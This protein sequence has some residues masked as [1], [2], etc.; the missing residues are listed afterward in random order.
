MYLKIVWQEKNEYLG[1]CKPPP[2]PPPPRG[3]TGEEGDLATA[4]IP[5]NQSGFVTPT[6]TSK[7]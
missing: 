7:I 1:G 4:D 2:P 5:T 3:G 6:N